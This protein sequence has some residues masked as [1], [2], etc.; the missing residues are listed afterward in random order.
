MDL[1]T[2]QEWWEGLLIGVGCLC[3][4]A[5]VITALL[6]CCKRR[7]IHR[8]LLSNRSSSGSSAGSSSRKIVK[9]Q[10]S[11][12]TSTFPQGNE[13]SRMG[14]IV[15]R[16]SFENKQFVGS[17]RSLTS[18]NP[19]ELRFN[20][21]A[22]PSFSKNTKNLAVF[23]PGV[24]IENIVP[25]PVF[26]SNQNNNNVMHSTSYESPCFDAALAANLNTNQEGL[27][28]S[29]YITGKKLNISQNE[30]EEYYENQ[31]IRL[32]LKQIYKIKAFKIY[33][34]F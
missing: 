20:P 26:V 15:T 9:D 23:Y 10:F 13:F 5:I 18:L 11:H 8:S 25:N 31:Q 32:K 22:K 12:L 33:S 7:G 24:P 16:N 6:V 30:N 29:V 21:T 1:K 34:F 14:G 27:V 19:S 3:F 2:V 28:T 17:I 4:A